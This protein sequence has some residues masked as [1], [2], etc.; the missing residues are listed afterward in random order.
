MLLDR[1][2]PR[3]D[4]GRAEI[5]LDVEQVR[6]QIPGVG[7]PRV[8]QQ[9]QPGEDGQV[10]VIERPDLEGPADQEAAD[11]EPAPRLQFMEQEPA[12]EE[13]AEDEEEVNS[14]PA[15]PVPNRRESVQRTRFFGSDG[16][17]PAQDQEDRDP[18]E[19]VELDQARVLHGVRPC[20]R[21]KV[22]NPERRRLRDPEG[23]Q[24]P[25]IGRRL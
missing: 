1:Q 23:R 13:T 22:R 10:Q 25:K 6:E 7:A 4:A 12:H 20:S 9:A 21:A 24:R 2:A 16:R 3:M 14:R 11:V 18:P 19:D 17:M 15:E 8:G 5:I